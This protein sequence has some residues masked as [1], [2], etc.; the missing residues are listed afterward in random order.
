MIGN[1]E[2]SCHEP[3]LAGGEAELKANMLSGNVFRIIAPR[4]SPIL[5]SIRGQKLAAAP[6]V[7]IHLAPPMSHSKLGLPDPAHAF[8]GLRRFESRR[9]AVHFSA[10][11]SLMKKAL[12]KIFVEHDRFYA[13]SRIASAIRSMEDRSHERDEGILGQ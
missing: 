2:S 12:V 3:G 9:Q 6:T 10:I 8:P 11:S 5:S 1:R 4:S 7:R 13:A